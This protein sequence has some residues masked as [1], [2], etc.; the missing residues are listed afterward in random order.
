MHAGFLA[1]NFI[2]QKVYAGITLVSVG[3]D[4]VGS[5]MLANVAAPESAAEG[6]LLPV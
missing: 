2:L 4:G 3:G 5:T 1:P 6:Q